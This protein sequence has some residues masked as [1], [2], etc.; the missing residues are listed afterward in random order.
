LGGGG[1]K[2][3]EY[4]FLAGNYEGKRPV[5]RFSLDGRLISRWISKKLVSRVWAGFMSNKAQTPGRGGG[6]DGI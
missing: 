4:I 3:S 6:E 1:G 2:S 5:G